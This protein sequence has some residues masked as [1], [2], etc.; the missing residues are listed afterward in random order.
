MMPSHGCPTIRW[1]RSHAVGATLVSSCTPTARRSR[2]VVRTARSMNACL[3]QVK[4]VAAARD[5]DPQE[6]RAAIANAQA[7]RLRD[8]LLRIRCV[9]WLKSS[10][11]R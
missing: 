10:P 11:L 4:A 7:E 1:A 8:H 9:P 2:H 3:M 5:H 6:L